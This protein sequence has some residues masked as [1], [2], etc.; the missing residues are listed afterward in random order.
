MSDLEPN[1]FDVLITDINENTLQTEVSKVFGMDYLA[2]ASEGDAKREVDTIDGYLYG[3]ARRAMV[4]CVV[5][6]GDK[7]YWVHFIVDTLSPW[8]FV[9]EKVNNLTYTEIILSC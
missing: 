2:N 7:A 3:E 6:N 4:P 5:G 9:S 8:T 1:A